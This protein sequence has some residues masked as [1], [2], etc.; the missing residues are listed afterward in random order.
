M[1]EVCLRSSGRRTVQ[2]SHLQEDAGRHAGEVRH[3]G[4]HV[5]TIL[6]ESRGRRQQRR[7]TRHQRGRVREVEVRLE[8]AQMRSSTVSG[9]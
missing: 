9:R 4:V 6:A 2:G 3:V 1:P 5:L 8:A 7:R